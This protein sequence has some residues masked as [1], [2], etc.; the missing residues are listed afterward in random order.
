MGERPRDNA[1]HAVLVKKQTGINAFLGGD[2][3][4]MQP[5]GFDTEFPICPY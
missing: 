1:P 5:P 4:S 3:D 2:V